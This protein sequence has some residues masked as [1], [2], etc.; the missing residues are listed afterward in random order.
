MTTTATTTPAVRYECPACEQQYAP[1][2]AW[3]CCCGRPLEFVDR[4]ELSDELDRTRG[5]W[6]GGLPPVGP[7]ARLGAGWTPLVAGPHTAVSYKL[8]GVNPTGSFKDRG[9]A[10]TISL[11]DA[12]GVDRVCEDSSGNAGTAIATYAARAGIDAEIYVP[13][14]ADSGKLR[15]IERTGAKLV[16][17]EGSRQ[18]AT[19][20]CHDAVAAGRGWYASHAWQPAFLTGTASIAGEIYA[21]LGGV[22]DAVVVPTGHGTLLLGL[23]RGFQALQAAGKTAD[24]DIGTDTLPRLY[25]AQAAGTAPVVAAHH[26]SNAAAGDNDLADGIQVREPA[27]E[28]QIRAAVTNTDGTALAIGAD[29]TRRHRDRLHKAGSASSRPV[30]SLRRRWLLSATA[31]RS[32]LRSRLS[33]R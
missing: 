4:P 30:R 23:Y 22:P 31:A 8:E 5:V 18:Q 27:R 28:K 12:L 25:A 3:R 16:R 15:A 17:V 13:A 10:V 24:A 1:T 20:A 29:A 33:Y 2:E 14:D 7:R 9:A 26:D 11:A 32:A 21:Q 19:A 6:A